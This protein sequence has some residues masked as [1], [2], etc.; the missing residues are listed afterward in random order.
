MHWKGLQGTLT[1]ELL[2]LDG[3]FAALQIPTSDVPQRCIDYERTPQLEALPV[4]EACV[5]HGTHY[6]DVTGENHLHRASYDNF[7]EQAMASKSLVIHSCGYDSVP[8]DLAGFL[9]VNKLNDAFGVGCQ[10]LK[11]FGG[12]S[13]GGF[14]G[15]TL[16]TI[17]GAL[18]GRTKDYPGMKEAFD[19][20]AYSAVRLEHAEGNGFAASETGSAGA[21]E[22]TAGDAGRP[23]TTAER[24]AR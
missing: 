9:A 23:A 15:G 16:A 6:I 4:V 19:R 24:G 17:L 8:S 18:T 7:H 12:E 11:T 3:R 20:E 22:T 10:E 1:F 21:A 13:K 5:K 14:S 2:A